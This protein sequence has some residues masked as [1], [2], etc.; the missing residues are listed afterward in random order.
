MEALL[1]QASCADPFDLAWL[2]PPI[3]NDDTR[4]VAV[5]EPA[6]GRLALQGFERGGQPATQP[7]RLDAV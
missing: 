1:A 5:A 7:L 4:L 2:A 3:L 6:T